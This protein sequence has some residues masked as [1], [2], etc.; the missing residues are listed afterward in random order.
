MKKYF[1]SIGILVFAFV[2]L[3]LLSFLF[4]DQS[5]KKN[6]SDSLENYNFVDD[7]K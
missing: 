3:L 6:V 4:D 1:I 5:I 2:F 7:E